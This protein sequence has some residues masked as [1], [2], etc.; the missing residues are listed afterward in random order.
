MNLRY[1]P[2]WRAAQ[3]DECNELAMQW[4]GEPS[5]PEGLVARPREMEAVSLPQART[6]H[7]DDV[8]RGTT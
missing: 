2:S 4:L 8:E 5:F 3:A 6:T 1:L 7:L